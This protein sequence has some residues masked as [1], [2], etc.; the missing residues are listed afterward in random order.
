MNP[1]PDQQPL[2][3]TKEMLQEGVVHESATQH[4]RWPVPEFSEVL[5]LRLCYKNIEKI[6][7][8][9]DFL[10]LV[11]LDLNC[12]LIE[13]IQGLGGLINLTWLDLSFNKIE[14][15]EGLE[16]L[17][18]LEMLNLSDNRISV[19]ENMDTLENLTHFY[20]AN[21]LLG[22]L[23]N[24]LYLK[25]FKFLYDV[26]LFGNPLPE[27][28]GYDFFIAA[29]FPNLRRIDFKVI[30]EDTKNGASIR[31]A[32]ASDKM[33]REELQIQQANEVQ[34]R[35]EAQLKLHNDAFVEFLNGPSLFKSMFQDDPEA[36]TLHS[37]PGVDSLIETF[38]HQMVELCIQ[39]FETGMADHKQREAE[40][41]SFF[42][43]QNKA[44]RDCQ[45]KSSQ[46]LDKGTEDLR[47]V[48]DEDIREV[49][50]ERLCSSILKLEVELFSQLEDE[51]QKLNTSLSDMADNFSKT[52][53]ATYPF[54]IFA[55]CRDLEDEYNQKVRQVAIA[56]LEKVAMET[57]VE[58]MPVDVTMLF[59]DKDIV[60][61]ALVTSHDNHLVRINDRETELVTRFTSW[62]VN[63]FKG[64]QST[65]LARHRMRISEIHRYGD[66]LKEQ[67]VKL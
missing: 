9:W 57:E 37:V 11:R 36:E 24:V 14:K 21:N 67:V 3:I 16:S 43:H 62:K 22:Q 38:E 66:Y 12:N 56:T 20:L 44:E 40:V 55:Q 42:S 59:A 2:L 13:K 8:I 49:R 6:A 31:Y 65:E 58:N 4:Q 15:I 33:R 25:K 32:I 28:E 35:R 10:S 27:E 47:E 54:L 63:L 45:Q 7:Q 5:H 1:S 64:I 46:M 52:V 18:K 34:Q 17:Q 60:M 30:D 41:N 61:D 19:I 39:L 23:D 50:I 53:H 26:S 29:H 48:L 51:I